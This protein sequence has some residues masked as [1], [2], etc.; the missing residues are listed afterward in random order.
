MFDVIL[1]SCR[2]GVRKPDEKIY[3]LA[4]K[5]LGVKPDEVHVHVRDTVVLTSH[6]LITLQV[7]FLDDL[8]VNLKGANRLGMRTIL[9]RDPDTAI[10]ELQQVLREDG[11][12]TVD[13]LSGMNLHSR[14]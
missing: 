8:G 14:L 12:I 3:W 2:L 11:D 9:V 4:C 6:H 7:V 1:E 5:K 10:E 13:L